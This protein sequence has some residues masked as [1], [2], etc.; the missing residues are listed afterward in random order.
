[1]LGSQVKREPQQQMLGPRLKCVRK[2]LQ[3]G[4]RLTERYTAHRIYHGSQ[5]E[6]SIREDLFRGA[7]NGSVML[8]KRRVRP[9]A[10]EHHLQGQIIRIT[11]GAREV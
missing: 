1:M 3:K 10:L 4:I 6:P 2:C 11:D 8:S 7:S 9:D 5:N